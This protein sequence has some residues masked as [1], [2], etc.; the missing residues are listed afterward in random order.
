[1]AIW[2]SNTPEVGSQSHVDDWD[3][4]EDVIAKL[5]SSASGPGEERGTPPIAGGKDA[6][7]VRVVFNPGRPP[8][9]EP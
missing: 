6:R 4:I 5:G 1:M 9:A 7:H 3:S 8:A 2:W